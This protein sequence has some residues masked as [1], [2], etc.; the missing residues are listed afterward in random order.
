MKPSGPTVI[1]EIERRARERP[2]AAALTLLHA[3]GRRELLTARELRREAVAWGRALER[4]GIGEGDLVLLVVR[5]SRAL[6][7]ALVGAL[8]RRALPSVFPF[9]SERLD[10]EVYVERVRALVQHAGVKTVIA[11]REDVARL[12]EILRPTGC[13]LLTVGDLAHEDAGDEDPRWPLPEPDDVACLH[14]SSGT[15]GMQKAITLPHRSILASVRNYGE[16]LGITPGDVV[17]SWMPLYHDGGLIMGFMIPLLWEIPLVL[18]SPFHWVRAPQDMFKAV[19]EFEGTLTW[20]PNFAYNHC[21]RRIRDEDLEGVDVSSW[22]AITNAAEPVRADSHR[23][24]YERFRRFGLRESALCTSYGMA[25]CTALVTTSRMGAP[26][27]IDWVDRHALQ[28]ERHARPAAPGAPGAIAVVG[29]GYPVRGAELRVIDAQGN[30][31]PERGVGQILVRCESMFKGYYKRPDL[32]E[33]VMRDGWHVSGDVGY[34]A[35]GQIHVTGR[36]KDLIIVAGRNIHPEDLEDSAN[37]VEGLKR[38]RCV[39]F[40][41]TDPNLGTEAVVMVC[42]LARPLGD[43]ERARV[44]EEVRRR[45]W[46]HEVAL[47]DVRLVDERW[48]IKTS[49]GKISRSANREKYLKAGF[50]PDLEG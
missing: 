46:Q 11:D 9:L 37:E 32:T 15:T 47:A 5:H 23:M 16:A 4:A 48:M 39:A 49:S 29:S 20:M 17:V 18:M 42:E 36:L 34:L 8:Y 45:V 14:H 21:A 2:H 50:R 22:R 35:G 6:P 33:R 3:D 26:A 28:A 30:D 44:A 25:E 13:R 24:F 7:A 41:L 10:P 19:H 40:G 43:D 31:L 1:H 12:G 38:G 27:E